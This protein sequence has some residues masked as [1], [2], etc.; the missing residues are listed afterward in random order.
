MAVELRRM[1]G[2]LR[3]EIDL[4]GDFVSRD[5][6]EVAAQEMWK[7]EGYWPVGAALGLN[8]EEHWIDL[9]ITDASDEGEALE[10]VAEQRDIEGEARKLY[11]ATGDERLRTLL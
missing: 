6:F 5:E 2:V 3:V 10:V 1:R 8:V 11:A 4:D 9:E 7:A